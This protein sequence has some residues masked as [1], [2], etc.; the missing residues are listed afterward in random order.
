MHLKHPMKIK[1]LLKKNSKHFMKVK[2]LTRSHLIKVKIIK[3]HNESQE[4]QNT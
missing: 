1:T 4:S 3:T 2:T